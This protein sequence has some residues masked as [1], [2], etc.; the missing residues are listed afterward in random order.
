M[1]TRRGCSDSTPMW[2]A[3]RQGRRRRRRDSFRVR[4]RSQD[5]R[6]RRAEGN[7][8]GQQARQWGGGQRLVGAH[9]PLVGEPVPVAEKRRQCPQRD[10]GKAD[11][12][13]P[14]GNLERREELCDR[15]AGG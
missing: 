6:D 9:G 7:D 1:R 4:E 14:T 3:P 11:E 15:E 2:F 10:E 12:P 5:E 13:A 8:D